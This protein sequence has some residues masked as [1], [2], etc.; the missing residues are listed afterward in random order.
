MM[1]QI[2]MQAWSLQRSELFIKTPQMAPL[3]AHP[4]RRLL[5]L[6]ALLFSGPDLHTIGSLSCNLGLAN[7]RDATTT[8]VLTVV[9]Q[10][11]LGYPVPQP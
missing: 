5:S 9:F 4:G 2:Q 1:G 11:I 6:I 3:S 7:F 10:V 8:T